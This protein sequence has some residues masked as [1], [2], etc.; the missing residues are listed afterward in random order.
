MEQSGVTPA[1]LTGSGS[2]CFALC[3]GREDAR[4]KGETL[5]KAWSRRPDR[6]IVMVLSSVSRRPALRQI[7][8]I[9]P[10]VG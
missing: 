6:G 9:G 5:R 4:Q 10:A 8:A 7:P 3:E 2:A 1:M